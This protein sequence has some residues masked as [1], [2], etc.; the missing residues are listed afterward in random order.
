[1]PQA[2]L[3]IMQKK[4]ASWSV[5]VLSF[6]NSSKDKIGNHCVQFQKRMEM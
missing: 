5:M 2:E 1:M 3:F 4:V 6:L